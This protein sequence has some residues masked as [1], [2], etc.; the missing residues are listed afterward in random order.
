ME[1]RYYITPDFLGKQIVAIQWT[2]E[3]LDQIKKLFP[4]NDITLSGE[5]LSVK[6]KTYKIIVNIGDYL[7]GHYKDEG[8]LFST[9]SDIFERERT[10]ASKYIKE[11]H[12][13]TQ[14]YSEEEMYRWCKEQVE[15][16]ET[17]NPKFEFYAKR[18]GR[19]EGNIEPLMLIT[20]KTGYL[21]LVMN[22]N[23]I[24]PYNKSLTVLDDIEGPVE[25]IATFSV[26]MGREV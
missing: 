7:E 14:K 4:D 23:Q 19:L 11:D 21:Q 9:P 6:Y 13:E 12:P 25:V 20:D 5:D 2:G 8:V 18:P 10:P 16:Y 15:A 22:K 24:I 26:N 3:N 17:K 1:N